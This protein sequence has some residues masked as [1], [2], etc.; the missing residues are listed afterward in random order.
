MSNLSLKVV[1]D[2][3]LSKCV[4]CNF[5]YNLKFLGKYLI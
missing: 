1:R 4:V 2:S 3:I 5:I